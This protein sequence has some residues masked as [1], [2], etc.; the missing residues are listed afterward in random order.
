MKFE[1]ASSNPRVTSSNPGVTISNSRV[2]GSNLP[3]TSSNLRVMSSNLRTIESM[4]TQVTSLKTISFPKIISP[5]LFGN[6]YGNS[7]I[8]FLVI[9]SC[10]LVPLLRGYGFSRGLKKYA[11]TLKERRIPKF[12]LTMTYQA[13][14]AYQ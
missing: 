14:I 13:M 1:S 6:P 7:C 8:Q 2:R 10:F 11:I 9:I 5:K 4:K 3:F 12:S